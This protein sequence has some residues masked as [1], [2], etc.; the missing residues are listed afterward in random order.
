MPNS[1]PWDGREPITDAMVRHGVRED[2]QAATDR[3]DCAASIMILCDVGADEATAY[4]IVAMLV[5]AE[6]EPIIG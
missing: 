6:D 1:L 4:E 5:P 3:G 2:F